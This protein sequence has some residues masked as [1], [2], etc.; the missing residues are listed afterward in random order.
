MGIYR[1]TINS[2]I[3]AVHQ[4]KPEWIISKEYTPDKRPPLPFFYYT[5]SDDYKRLSFNVIEG[6]PFLMAVSITSVAKDS[7][8]ASDNAHD[9][10]M[11]LQSDLVLSTLASKGISV[12][13]EQL[14]GNNIDFGVA[15]ESESH[16]VAYLTVIDGWKDTTMSGE[17][18]DVGIT[19]N[20][21]QE[22]SNK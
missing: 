13:V 19:S 16:L 5:I 3:Q 22:E 7:L 11:I 4:V 14:P 18:D 6:E 21:K 10:R 9:M 12:S 20:E 1:Q 15:V 2:L 8:D 17:L